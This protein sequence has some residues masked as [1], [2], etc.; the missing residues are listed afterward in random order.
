M[1]RNPRFWIVSGLP[2]GS[3]RAVARIE[4]LS[5]SAMAVQG[6][7][8]HSA[9]ITSDK[10][11]SKVPDKANK[12]ATAPWKNRAPLGVLAVLRSS[13]R[14]HQ[15]TLGSSGDSPV[16]GLPPGHFAATKSTQV[17][18]VASLRIRSVG[19]SLPV[20][21]STRRITTLADSWFAAKR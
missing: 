18:S 3:Y 20:A 19:V 9:K 5:A 6:R 16:R 7:K 8:I 21:E 11:S 4:V 13:T 14:A 2:P 17:G 12:A 10:S 1:S 15:F